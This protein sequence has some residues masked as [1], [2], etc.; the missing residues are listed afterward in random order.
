MPTGQVCLEPSE[1]QALA[2]HVQS[3]KIKD[4]NFESMDRAYKA[5]MD[6]KCN[7]S[8]VST[9]TVSFFGAGLVI[10]ILLKLLIAPAK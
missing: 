7:E 2:K 5:C 8:L 1:A 6:S 3:C 9:K 10:G 4:K